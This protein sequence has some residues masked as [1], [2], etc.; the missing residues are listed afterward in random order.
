MVSGALTEHY[1][2]PES[3]LVVVYTRDRQVLLLRRHQP[4]YFWQSPAG[5]M[6]WN[7]TPAV[8]A[9]RELCEETSLEATVLKW[10]GKHSY[11]IYPMW[12]QRYAPGVIENTEHMFHLELN[13]VQEI[14]MDSREH[15][16][17]RW[18]SQQEAALL[19]YSYTNRVAIGC[20]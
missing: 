17:Y 9:Q 12:R 20:L 4:T 1:K 14:V 5:S 10:L 13:A 7:E 3:V 11:I 19:A 8:A 18:L 16:E 2:R 15:S 6:K